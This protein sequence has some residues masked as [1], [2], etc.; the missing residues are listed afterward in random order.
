MKPK[1]NPEA[2]TIIPKWYKKLNS[3]NMNREFLKAPNILDIEDYRFCVI[4]EAH[5]F[6]DDYRKSCDVCNDMSKR[7]TQALAKTKISYRGGIRRLENVPQSV[8]DTMVS[9]TNKFLEHYVKKHK[10]N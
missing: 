8:I 5:G 3:G 1:L 7:I 10:R 4:G 6:T 2:K 9:R